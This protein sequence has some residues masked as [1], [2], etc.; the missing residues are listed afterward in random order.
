MQRSAKLQPSGFDLQPANEHVEQQASEAPQHEMR[1]E[2][3]LDDMSL[4]APADAFRRQVP[5]L[6][7]KPDAILAILA[8]M[9]Q[10]AMKHPAVATAACKALFQLSSIDDNNDSKIACAGGCKIILEAMR[11][12]KTVADVQ[13][14]GCRALKNLAATDEAKKSISHEGG[15]QVILD[16][17]RHHTQQQHVTEHACQALI[18][19]VADNYD[20]KRVLADQGG[21]RLLL[22]TMAA[23]R[24]RAE[25]QHYACRLLLSLTYNNPDLKHKVVA[26]Q[27]I[28]EI[29]DTMQAH[30]SH[31]GVQ[32]MACGALDNIAWSDQLLR[33][34][35][36][37]AG[38]VR[39]VE[40][41]MGAHFAGST[42]VC[43]IYGQHLLSNL[44]SV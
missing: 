26:E 21:I 23:H 42:E 11:A 20:N 25:I 12:H 3:N 35:V 5:A 17:M 37:D 7:K 8:G 36:K 6:K 22:Q 41:A 19:L 4:D 14:Q 33:K 28:E 27:G 39:V 15:I 18:N 10:H 2:S 13:E 9:Q 24:Q 38:A 34:R 43:K 1:L 32:E 29:L 16:A 30:E 44:E 31:V 40:S